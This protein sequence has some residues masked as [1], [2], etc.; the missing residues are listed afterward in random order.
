MRKALIALAASSLV[1]GACAASDA[2]TGTSAPMSGAVTPESANAYVNAAGAS[3]QFEI[4]SSQIALTKAQRPEVRAFAQ[5]M[6]DHHA[7]TTRALMAAARASGITPPAPTLMP[8]QREMIEALQQAPAASFDQLY[9][10]QQIPAHEMAL[11]LHRTYAAQGDAPELQ[12]TARAAVP[13]VERH[14]AQARQLN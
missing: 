4:Q 6:I 3:D 12:T 8:M 2:G 9:V 5:T 10:S 11:A 1:L 13:I 7:A 14:L